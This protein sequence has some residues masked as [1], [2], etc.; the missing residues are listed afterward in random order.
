MSNFCEVCKRSYPEELDACPH[1]AEAAELVEEDA[2]E[3]VEEPPQ[4][5]DSAAPLELEPDSAIDLGLPTLPSG[6]EGS[7]SGHSVQWA[8]LVEE[9]PIPTEPASAVFDD[10]ADAD[11]LPPPVA[12]ASEERHDMPAAEAV[13]PPAVNEPAPAQPPVSD[14]GEDAL[15]P[16]RKLV[17]GDVSASFARHVPPPQPLAE[18]PAE[19]DDSALDLH[20]PN[21][22]EPARAAEA[23][24]AEPEASAIDLGAAD[25]IADEPA[26]LSAHE[27][28]VEAAD[29]GIDLTTAELEEE[30]VAE[31]VGEPPAAA[32]AEVADS[33]IDLSA[34]VVAEPEAA[35]PSAE[36][37]PSGIDLT[38][39]EIVAEPA[40]APDLV[41][42]D[43]D[44]DL[45]ELMEEES[46]AQGEPAA[47]V[48]ADS[49]IDLTATEVVAP[50]DSSVLSAEVVT[51]DSGLDLAG[52]VGDEAAIEE[53]DAV[54]VVDSGVLLGEAE[55]VTVDSGLDLAEA[56]GDEAAIEELDAVEVVDSGVLLGETEAVVQPPADELADRPEESED[57]AI[58]LADVFVVDSS[59]QLAGTPLVEEPISNAGLD[60]S[61][62]DLLA[63]DSGRD[64]NAEDAE[65][66]I[67]LPLEEIDLV[68]SSSAIEPASG[69][70]D[71][72]VDE[73]AT[74][75]AAGE[76]EAVEEVDLR[77]APIRR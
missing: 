66:A 5:G 74:A 60:L 49:G 40:S 18:P 55:V 14:E 37:S 9:E 6:A 16:L 7:S 25:V 47:D 59:V 1:C 43:S 30:V 22:D 48:Q 29:S 21:G 50:P 8:E 46:P 65:S 12:A 67:N 61:G 19:D 56:V 76:L 35:E 73:S 10:P 52:A 64:R 70:V 32:S 27:E 23:P 3:L 24:A 33:G 38:D 63:S 42:A 54:E 72:I 26:S 41:T 34:F 69:R 62:E 77:E 75:L 17:S 58:D 39:A 28:A 53:L 13:A 68:G 20:H 31:A 4:T 45:K 71:E 11:L 51:V 44:I 36:A 2:V 57:S 15:E